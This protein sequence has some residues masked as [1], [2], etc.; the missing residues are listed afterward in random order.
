M[1]M[2]SPTMMQFSLGAPGAKP[3]KPAMAMSG[4]AKTA[5]AKMASATPQTQSAQRVH[6][7]TERIV[8]PEM[9]NSVLIQGF[10]AIEFEGTLVIRRFY[11]R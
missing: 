3:K 1:G 8:T 11:S 7:V 10:E 5:K 9:R 2:K 4:G 6:L